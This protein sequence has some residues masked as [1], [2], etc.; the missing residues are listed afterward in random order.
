[1]IHLGKNLQFLRKKS[2]L[3]QN[4]MPKYIDVTRTTW[5]N[6]ENNVSEPDLAKLSVIAILFG[7]TTDQLLTVNLAHDL[8]LNFGQNFKEPQSLKFENNSTSLLQELQE[9]NMPNTLNQILVMME[10]MSADIELLKKNLN[11]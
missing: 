7:V 11:I 5:G 2:G 8:G 3:T 9:T 1:M 4:D 6:Y 10:Q